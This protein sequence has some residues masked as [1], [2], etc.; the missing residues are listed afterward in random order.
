MITQKAR[1]LA[2]DL[3]AVLTEPTTNGLKI[4]NGILDLIAELG[5]NRETAAKLMSPQA[6]CFYMMTLLIQRSTSP[7]PF[8]LVPQGASVLPPAVDPPGV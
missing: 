6:Q 5:G 2:V 3:Q 7:P 8:T 4:H 1:S